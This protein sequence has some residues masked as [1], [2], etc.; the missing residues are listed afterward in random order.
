MNTERI[1]HICVKIFADWNGA[2]AEAAVPVFH[3][4][5]QEDACE[6]L[7]I[8]VVEYLHV[9]GGPGVILVG[10]EAN[11][12]LDF[13]GNRPGIL[14]NRKTAVGGRFSAKLTQ[15]YEAAKG[16]AARL[17]KEPEF[18]GR[19]RFD[20]RS[21]AIIVNDRLLAPN[22]DDTWGALR[23]EIEQFVREFVGLS[24]FTLRRSEDPRER[25]AVEVR[26]A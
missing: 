25:F 8:D 12:S 24:A 10:H 6:E 7:L 22:T 9:E 2:N 13:A 19:V 14:Y 26:P 1:E 18:E 15:A 3:R 21:F 11:Y 20:P 17:E 16:A 4:W 5:I 23:P